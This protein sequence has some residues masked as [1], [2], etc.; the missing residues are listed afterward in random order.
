MG[1]CR[2]GPSHFSRRDGERVAQQRAWQAR[3]AIGVL[4]VEL[5]AATPAVGRSLLR[6]LGAAGDFLHE[7]LFASTSDALNRGLAV[8]LLT[9]F[10]RPLIRGLVSMRFFSLVVLV[11]A[12]ACVCHIARHHD[13]WQV[14]SYFAATVATGAVVVRV[15]ASA[16]LWRSR[17]QFDVAVTDE[18]PPILVLRSFSH[19]RLL[20]RPKADGTRGVPYLAEITRA[21]A[22]FGLPVM[23]GQKPSADDADSGYDAAMFIASTDDDWDILFATAAKASAAIILIPETTAG[24]VRETL[25]LLGSE[26]LQKTL[27]VMPRADSQRGRDVLKERWEQVQRAWIE[28]GF[29]LPEYRDEGLIFRPTPVFEIAVGWTIETSGIGTALATAFQAIVSD[30]GVNHPF[31]IFAD[32]V[33]LRFEVPA[34]SVHVASPLRRRLRAFATMFSPLDG[35]NQ[36]VAMPRTLSFAQAILRLPHVENHFVSGL[37]TE[38]RAIATA[39][40]GPDAGAKVAAGGS[41]LDPHGDFAG[42]STAEPEPVEITPP[43]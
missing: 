31:S 38:Y 36:E 40:R 27:V 33:G 17:H 26:L 19:D 5:L 37:S 23:L 22:P 43:S 41:D 39:M 35:A 13:S 11:Y 32:A 34:G 7:T 9:A 3:F 29:R 8:V 28:A 14:W 16:E 30:G 42:D 21:V 1:Q 15:G 12:A 2:E 18:R 24:L 25:R 4:A 20:Y 6:T 10:L